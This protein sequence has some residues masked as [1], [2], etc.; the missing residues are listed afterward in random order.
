[1]SII[2]NE[3][4]IAKVPNRFDLVL[5]ASQRVR[6]LNNGIPPTITGNHTKMVTALKEISAGNLDIGKLRE[7]Q[8]TAIQKGFNE[9]ED[10][11]EEDQEDKT[12]ESFEFNDEGLAFNDFDY[13]EECIDEP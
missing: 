12:I 13:V 10:I 9:I 3:D 2:I 7:A 8:I 11:T 4:C 6:D 1:M 5:L